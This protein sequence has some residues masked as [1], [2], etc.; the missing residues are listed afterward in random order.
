MQ[1]ER[2]TAFGVLIGLAAALGLAVS[3]AGCSYFAG[4]S[5]GGREQASTPPA[6]QSASQGQAP[7]QTGS[8]EQTP[9]QPQPSARATS[10]AHSAPS[11]QSTAP[12]SPGV[13][14]S[15]TPEGGKQP[16]AAANGKPRS[17]TASGGSTA[18]SPA[19]PETARAAP[20]GSPPSSGTSSQKAPAGTAAAETSAAAS[21]RTGTSSAG[22]SS[23]QPAAPALDLTSLEQRLRDTHAIGVFTKLSLKNQVDDLLAAFRAFHNKQ[24]ARTLSQLRQQYDGLLLKVLS[25]LQDGDPSLAAAISSSREALWGILTDPQKFSKI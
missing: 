11:A 2:N 12:S 25:L 22:S 23:A 21:P 18:K 13:P 8:A 14:K 1:G 24:A 19:G 16:S 15:A 4:R 10:P 6:P 17:S 20:A 9:A 7:A 3:L 5:S